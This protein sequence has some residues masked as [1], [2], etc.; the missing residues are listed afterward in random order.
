MDGR[1]PMITGRLPILFILLCAGVARVSAQPYTNSS[2]VLDTSG[3]QSSAAPYS[4]TGACGQPGGIGM[5]TGGPF[6]NVSGFLNTSVFR[7]GSDTDGDGLPDEVDPD[8][9]NDGLADDDELAGRA[10][11][12]P[13]ATDVNNPDSDGD[14]F[15]D[16]AEAA[17]GTDPSSSASLL[18]ITSIRK[19]TGGVVVGWLARD[20]RSYQ[21]ERAGALAGIGFLTGSVATV[22]AQGPGVPPWYAITNYF[23]D[24]NVTAARAAFYRI[25]AVAP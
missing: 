23:T 16:G 15:R 6:V 5:S 25:G 20:S 1:I 14:G 2:W 11:Q 13:T 18:T 19:T 12:P 22:T 9:D 17:A 8:N 10:F 21:V 4:Q 3:I 24:T 7:P